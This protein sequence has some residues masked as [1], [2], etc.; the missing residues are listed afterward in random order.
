MDS[1]LSMLCVFKSHFACVTHQS[2][3]RIFCGLCEASVDRQRK[4]FNGQTEF[5]ILKN[6]HVAFFT[7]FGGL[8]LVSLQAAVSSSNSDVCGL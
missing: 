3:I 7:G 8:G 2:E 4:H 6:C 1:S 5:C